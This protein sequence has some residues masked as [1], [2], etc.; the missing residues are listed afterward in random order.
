LYKNRPKARVH[1]DTIDPL[2]LA[3]YRLDLLGMKIQFMKEIGD[4]YAVALQN[5]AEGKRGGREFNEI[6]GTNARLQ[7][8]RD[9]TTRV[10]DMYSAEWLRENHPYWLGNVTVRFDNLAQT[11]QAKITEMRSVNRAKLPSSEEIGF[12][13]IGATPAAEPAVPQSPPAVPK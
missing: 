2:I 4:F 12:R 11:I 6:T 9:A 13:R 7:D 8:L 5:Q 1:A 3:G 10:R